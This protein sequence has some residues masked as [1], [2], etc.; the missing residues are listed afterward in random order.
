MKRFTDVLKEILRGVKIIV[1]ALITTCSLIISKVDDW[2]SRGAKWI[3]RVLVLSIVT[4]AIF[5]ISGIS[6][7]FYNEK[8]GRCR[9]DDEEISYEITL[10]GFRDGTKRIYNTE[11]RRYVSGKLNWVSDVNDGDSLAVFAVPHKRGYI[12]IYTGEIVIEAQYKKAWIF[13]EG[14]AAV[15][16]DNRLGFINSK[17]E[18]VIP[19][20]FE[21]NEYSNASYTFFNGL[22]IIDNKEGKYGIIDINGKWVIEPVYDKIRH[23]EKY[24]FIENE[25]KSGLLSIEGDTIFAT[26][27]ENIKITD[28][29]DFILLKNGE[30][31]QQDREGN[32]VK[33]SMFEQSYWLKYPEGYDECGDIKYLFAD[34][35]KYR[36]GDKYGIMHRINGTFITPAIYS[37]INMLSANIFEAEVPYTGVWHLVNNNGEIVKKITKHAY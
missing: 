4:A 19:F 27:Y 9:W 15:V 20:D 25:N 33:K 1:D 23:D 11:E 14:V 30:M 37:D 22:C 5:V 21:Y 6:Y 7:A 8:Y 32:I 28:E 24:I 29:G 17:N 13:S 35:M 2:W 18:V 16:K 3:R 34:Y 10:H 12:N 36:I 26:E 31:W